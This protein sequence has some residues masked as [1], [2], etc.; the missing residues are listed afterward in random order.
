MYFCYDNLNKII[1]A[2]NINTLPVV[3]LFIANGFG[4]LIYAIQLQ[5]KFPEEH[6]F[7]N[8]ILI[9]FFMDSC[10]IFISIFLFD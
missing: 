4:Q 5:R 9:F 7:N 1:V 2:F 10:G 3:I 6:N 8:S